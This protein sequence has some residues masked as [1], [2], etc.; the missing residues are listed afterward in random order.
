MVSNNLILETILQNLKYFFLENSCENSKKFFIHFNSSQQKSPRRQHVAEV[1]SAI[2]ML[3]SPRSPL[4]QTR[5][6]FNAPHETQNFF[7]TPNKRAIYY[8]AFRLSL[9]VGFLFLSCDA[10][11]PSRWFHFPYNDRQNFTRQQQQT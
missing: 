8:F 11:A 6:D 4:F 10:M 3:F 2:H 1:L 9:E 7:S 5:I